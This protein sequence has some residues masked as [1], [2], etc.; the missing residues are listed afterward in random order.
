MS[1]KKMCKWK[2]K[3]IE[4]DLDAFHACVRDPRYVCTK[5]GR[6]AHKKGN[7]CKPLSMKNVK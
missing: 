7:V 3:K 1:D 5:C 4:K 6:V 2:P